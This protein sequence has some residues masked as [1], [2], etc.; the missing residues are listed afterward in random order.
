MEFDVEKLAK[1][2]RLSLTEE[3]KEE[4]AGECAAIIAYVGEIEKVAVDEPVPEAGELRNVMRADV[5]YKAPLA[6]PE[7]LLQEAPKTKDGF[8]E[9]KQLFTE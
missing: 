4:F 5:P 9:V 1:L 3:E 2:S 6:T 7:E 8:I